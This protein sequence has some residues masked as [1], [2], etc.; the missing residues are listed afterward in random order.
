MKV[1]NKTLLLKQVSSI[2]ATLD[3]R[4]I[5]ISTESA[6]A[7]VAALHGYKDWKALVSASEKQSQRLEASRW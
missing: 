4:R 1:P 6:Q 7:C 5:G 2:R 3:S